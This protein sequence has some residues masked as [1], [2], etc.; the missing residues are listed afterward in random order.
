MTGPLE[1][2]RLIWNPPVNDG[3]T[4]SDEYTF[5][6]GTFMME[7]PYNTP[8][9]HSTNTSGILWWTRRYLHD[10]YINSGSD[11]THDKLHRQK[12]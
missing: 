5:I 11:M 6:P 3:H 7:Y 10:K 9:V 4:E 1:P 8:S 2:V 12:N